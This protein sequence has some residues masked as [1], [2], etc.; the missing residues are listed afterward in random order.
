MTASGKRLLG[1]ILA[2]PL[3]AV[4]LAL[5]VVGVLALGAHHQKTPVTHR[6]QRVGL[7]DAQQMQLG[8]QEYTK[9]LA[10]DRA[11]SSPPAPV[12]PGCSALPGGS[13]P[14]RAETSRGSSGR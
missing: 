3:I 8:R 1:V 4:V 9:T 7:T 5:V 11:K 2:R 12:T 14:W 10:E 6:S 13:R